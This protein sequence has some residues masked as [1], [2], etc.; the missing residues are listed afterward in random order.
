MESI[1]SRASVNV[2]SILPNATSF[3]RDD[4]AFT[5]LAS[6]SRRQLRVKQGIQSILVFGRLRETIHSLYF[7]S[8]AAWSYRVEP[9]SERSV[10]RMSIDSGGFAHQPRLHG[11]SGRASL[12]VCRDSSRIER[13]THLS[14][15]A[16]KGAVLTRLPG[17]RWDSLQRL[18]PAA[19]VIWRILIAARPGARYT[20]VPQSTVRTEHP[21]PVT[22]RITRYCTA[23][24]FR[25]Q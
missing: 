8:G 24:F 5:G 23:K 25:L 20:I 15:R 21:S 19:E 10:K 4:I 14:C 3:R 16:R 1:D 22:D 17:G 12:F 11:Q 6:V 9:W 18:Q 13:R 7:G 2:L